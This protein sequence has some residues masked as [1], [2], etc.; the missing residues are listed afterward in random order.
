M[1]ECDTLLMVGTSFPY[2]EFMPE[3]G[4]ARAVQIDLD[5]MRIG[6]RYSVEVGLVGDGRRTLQHLLPL[7]RP[8]RYRGFLRNAQ[9]GMETVGNAWDAERPADEAGGCLPVPAQMNDLAT[10]CSLVDPGAWA[11]E[12]E[13]R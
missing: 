12:A 5:P 4:Q 7:L 2:L 1:E 10:N 9:R 11:T 8:N 13:E 6:L 3:P